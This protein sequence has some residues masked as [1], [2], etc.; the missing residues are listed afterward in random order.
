MGWIRSSL[1]F[2]GRETPLIDE[3]F[4]ASWADRLR[5]EIPGVVAVILKGSHARG[6]A[7]PWS[8]ID[9]DVLVF[10]DDIANDNLTWIVDDGSDR[11]VHVSVAVE[12]V[13]DWLAG[14]RKGA[15]WSFGFPG[16]ETT[17]LMWLGRPS[18][19]AELDRPNRDHPGGIP[20]LEDFIEEL[21]KA[22]NARMRGDEVAL[23]LAVQQIAQLCPA[24]LVPLNE[25]AFP[26]TRPEAINSAL[27]LTVVSPG[28]RDDMLLC[29]GLSG[30]ASTVDEVLAAGTRLVLGTVALLEENLDVY[31]PV[32]PPS[33]PQLLADGTLRRYLN[34]GVP[35]SNRVPPPSGNQKGSPQ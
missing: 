1:R 30:Q 21:G 13:D 25:P 26:G 3:A 34:Q 14:F 19:R 10:D 9:F 11:L 32:L 22:R 23:R 28:Y 5:R 24:L 33:L 6:A 2:A 29:L 15:S 17:R 18:L 8:D 7:N 27:D 16:K 20:E 31:A 12:R 4:I 35:D